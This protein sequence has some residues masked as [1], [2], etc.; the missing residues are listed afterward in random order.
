MCFA[1]S[2]EKFGSA[3]P[4]LSER[5]SSEVPRCVVKDSKGEEDR[6]ESEKYIAV[7]ID[8]LRSD[9]DVFLPPC[10]VPFCCLAGREHIFSDEEILN[11]LEQAPQHQTQAIMDQMLIGS[12]IH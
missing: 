1:K 5:S 6:M 4:F 2:K 10:C 7:N 8:K 12:H 3:E 9:G 11:I